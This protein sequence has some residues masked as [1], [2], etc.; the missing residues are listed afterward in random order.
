MYRRVAFITAPLVLL[1]SVVLL[2][3]SNIESGMERSE[4]TGETSHVRHRRD[5][6][7]TRSPDDLTANVTNSTVDQ[8]TGKSMSVNT[9]DHELPPEDATTLVNTIIDESQFVLTILGFVANIVTLVTLIKNGKDFTPTIALLLKHQSI[10]DAILCT[11]AA[12]LL[13]QPF[14]WVSGTYAF[15]VVLCQLWHGQGLYWNSCFISAY[16]LVLISYERFLCVCFPFKYQ[17]YT[18][19]SVYRQIGFVYVAGVICTIG[20]YMQSRIREDGKCYSEYSFDGPA[21]AT[22]FDVYTLS[23]VFTFYFIPTG[24]FIFFYGRV[25]WSFRKRQ[26]S[27]MAQSRVID[28]ATAELTKTAIVVTVIFIFSFGYDSLY[29]F[30]GSI[31]LLEYVLNAPVQ[32]IGV[33]LAVLNSCANPFVYAALMPSYRKAVSNTFFQVCSA[34]KN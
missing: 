6:S 26:A 1:I 28:K 29:Y 25:I 18:T 12:I 11:F 16:N 7:A 8:N 33:W 30:F 9:T 10:I 27:A 3:T 32:K 4:D 20:S 34:N 13:R 24:C 17:D 23:T 2:L 19:S 22:F 21:F 5:A 15:D 14:N 31:G